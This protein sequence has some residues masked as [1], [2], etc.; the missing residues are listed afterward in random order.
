[1]D[2]TKPNYIQDRSLIKDH[3]VSPNMS[4]AYLHS[5]FKLSQ[6][7]VYDQVNQFFNEQNQ[8]TKTVQEARD[9]LGESAQSLSDEQVHDLVTE[10]QYLVDSWLEEYEQKIFEGKT[11]KE[12]IHF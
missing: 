12:I 9:I 8:Q 2:N 10:I 5:N 6:E 7:N 4:P 1:M 3:S 11:L